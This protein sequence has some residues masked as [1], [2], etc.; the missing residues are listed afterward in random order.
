MIGSILKCNLLARSGFP[1]LLAWSMHGLSWI[2]RRARA[3]GRPSLRRVSRQA[4]TSRLAVV[5]AVRCLSRSPGLAC[6]PVVLEFDRADQDRNRCC[7][8]SRAHRL[9]PW[10]HSR[11]VQSL[12]RPSR[13]LHSSDPV[14]LP[15]GPPLPVVDGS[16]FCGSGAA[17]LCRLAVLA[18]SG[19]VGAGWLGWSTR[20]SSRRG[21]LVH[22]DLSRIVFSR[23]VLGRRL[24][25]GSSRAARWLAQQRSTQQ[26]RSKVL[27]RELL[28]AKVCGPLRLDGWWRLAQRLRRRGRLTGSSLP[29]VGVFSAASGVGSFCAAAALPGPAGSD[30]ALGSPF[31]SASFGSATSATEV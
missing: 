16:A 19:G 31:R 12:C 10:A 7:D 11:W 24:L 18:G 21:R 2:A 26:V 30:L 28:H 5:L 13:R 1:K 3:D 8:R 17:G 14:G 27:H 15:A 22:V 20:V 9:D 6:P 23:I 4:A 25:S 29:V